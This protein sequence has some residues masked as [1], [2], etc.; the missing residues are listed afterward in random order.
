M[1]PAAPKSTSS[2]CAAKTSTWR[3]LPASGLDPPCSTPALALPLPDFPGGLRQHLEQV[4]DDAEVRDLENRGVC[5]L[6]HRHDDLGGLHAGL[7]LD[8]TGDAGGNVQL[9]RNRL[10]GLAHLGGVLDP[11]GV[12]GGARCA[13]CATEGV[14]ELFDGTEVTVHAAAA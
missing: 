4:P 10:A 1:V 9:W 12:G 14:R 7:L 5:V 8:G 3:M 6:V 11:P 2:G 13:N